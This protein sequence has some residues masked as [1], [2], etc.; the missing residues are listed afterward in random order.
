MRI[1][2]GE[3]AGRK[4][5]VP[6]RESVRPTADR[7]RE[8]LFARLGAL[9]DM[10]VLDLFAGSGALGIEALSRG[11]REAVFVDRAAAC[12]S[13]VRSNLRALGLETCARVVRSPV[14]VAL[15]RP[16]VRGAPYDLVLLDPPYASEEAG[17]VLLALA[18]GGLV[19]A[20]GMVVLE[21]HHRH[22]PGQVEG[23]LRLDERRYGDTLIA[24][25]RPQGS[26]AEGAP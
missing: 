12:V 3:L 15:G 20:D 1:T 14:R 19:D 24:R 5:D 17:E 10:R 22:D 11:A 25:Y 6:R 4:I 13:Q 18:S 23:L 7:V 16:P 26:A 9:D 21:T 2:G 8:S